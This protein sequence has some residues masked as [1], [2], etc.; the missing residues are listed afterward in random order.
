MC[1][2]LIHARTHVRACVCA[3]KRAPPP[4]Y[5]GVATE[6]PRPHDLLEKAHHTMYWPMY[7]KY[8]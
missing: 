6:M 8:S 4:S 2:T 1:S 7:R 3:R 5:S